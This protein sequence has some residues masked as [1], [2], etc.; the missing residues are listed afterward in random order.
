MA[1][2]RDGMRGR[3]TDR[4]PDRGPGVF[5]VVVLETDLTTERDIRLLAPAG[6][7]I[8]VARAPYANPT[9]PEN[10]RATLPGLATAAGSIVPGVPLAALYFAC[11]S[12]GIVL[13]HDAVAAAFAGARPHVP[14]VTPADAAE[15]AL[16]A[17]GARRIGLVTPYLPETA[18]SVGAHFASRGFEIAASVALGM[19]DDRD[20]A[21]LA[22]EAILEAA[23]RAAVAEA[24]AVF[25]SCTA[26][27]ATEILPEIEAAVGRPVVT[28]NLA[29]L[30][31]AFGLA[32]LP[33]RQGFGRLLTSA[34][35][36]A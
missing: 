7:T 28:S 14:V 32:G 4:R 18:A 1:G 25:V 20:M 3:D 12:A 13:G 29:G 26:L 21:R 27:P 36:A 8:C 35:V 9:T 17:L 23:R 6:A 2:G 31:Q 34:A 30:W 19:A 16:A 10:L 11:T 22:P 5:G 33:T 15:R 24:E